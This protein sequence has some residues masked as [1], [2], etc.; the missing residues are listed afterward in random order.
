VTL[1]RHKR[2]SWRGHEC[3]RMV[4]DG[5]PPAIVLNILSEQSRLLR[6]MGMRQ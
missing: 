3:D 5:Q 6:W 1:R 4:A 2:Q